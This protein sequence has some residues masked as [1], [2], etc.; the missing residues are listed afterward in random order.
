MIRLLKNYDMMS[1]QLDLIPSANL[2]VLQ[3]YLGELSVIVPQNAPSGAP[4]E[5]SFK[6]YDWIEMD[7]I[8][9]VFILEVN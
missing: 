9:Q 5:F 3:P 2:K 6:V 1:N 8:E 4:R 7:T